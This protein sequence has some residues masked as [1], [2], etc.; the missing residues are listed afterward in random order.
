[1]GFDTETE[2]VNVEY[3]VKFYTLWSVRS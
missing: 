2:V 1:M 3:L